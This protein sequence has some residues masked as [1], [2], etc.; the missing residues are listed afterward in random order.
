[1]K[2]RIKLTDPGPGEPVPG[3][4]WH[5]GSGGLWQAVFEQ[6]TPMGWVEVPVIKD[7]KD[8]AK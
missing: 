1:M 5:D 4:C 2:I 3:F 6:N 7:D 8:E